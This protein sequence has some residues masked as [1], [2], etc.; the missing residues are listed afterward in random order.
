MFVNDIYVIACIMLELYK[1]AKE[2]H[3]LTQRII[4]TIYE[5]IV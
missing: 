3:L 1:V 2:F 5:A 4:Y